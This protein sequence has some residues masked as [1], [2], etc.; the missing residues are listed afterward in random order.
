MMSGPHPNAETRC[1]HCGLGI[2]NGRQRYCCI[3]CHLAHHLLRSEAESDGPSDRLLARLVISAF[4]AMGVMVFSLSLYGL[5]GS[6]T[7]DSARALQGLARLGALA[8][9]VPIFFLLGVP[10]LEAVVSMRRWLSS[11]ALVALGILSAW[12]LS[13]FNTFA[14]RGAVYFDT[15]TMVLVLFTLGRWLDARARE[16]ASNRLARLAEEQ[17]RPAT[18]VEAGTRG[19]ES[20]VPVGSLAVGDVVRVRPGETVPVDG[21][22]VWGRTFLETA[23]LTGESAPRSAAPGDRVWAGTRAVDGS[24]QVRAMAVEGHCV[25]D[26]IDRALAEAGTRRA[27][28]VRSADGVAAAFLPLVGIVALG[29]ALWHGL[30]SGAE[31]ALL[32][33]LSVLLIACP[34]ALGLATPLAFWVALGAAWREG[35]LV[36]GGDVLERLAR[37]RTVFFDKTGTLTS[38]E[39]A[40]E[41]IDC[42]AQATESEVLRMAAAVESASEHPIG[43]ALTRAW[44]RSDESALPAVEDFRALPGVGVEGVVEGHRVSLR[45]AATEELSALT[46]I[47]LELDGERLARMYLS[48]TLRAEAAPAVAELRAR[49]LELAALTGDG[50][51]PAAFLR[52]ELGLEVAGELLPHDKVERVRRERHMGSVFVGDGLNDAPVLA[53][54]DVGISMRSASATSLDSASVNLLTDDLRGVPR[55]IRLA[56]A[57]VR[58][59]RIN[60]VWAF[61]YNAVGIA[62]AAM[63][64]LTPVFAAT[65]MVLSSLMVVFHSFRLR[66]VL[67]DQRGGMQI[68]SR[69][70]ANSVDER[71]L[72][73]AH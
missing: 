40:L 44:R 52:Q 6:V 61:G 50:E 67:S 20:E 32:H 16:T 47:D 31:A 48:D 30:E 27:R 51:G 54:A 71:A 3:G 19:E 14:E 10:L 5:E 26:Q 21:E 38:G 45:R 58:T 64:R 49:G 41:R 13:A 73:G 55:A 60:L 4:L 62:L 66:N 63:G 72:Q 37:T 65:A 53:A 56:R 57:A 70:S 25:R 22:V 24:I 17:V 12:S 7:D 11:E 2:R 1:E 29:T 28:L 34:C 46:A 23:A 33:S 69:A 43:R 18:R 59:A 15:A 42:A 68:D 35:I 36:R 39:L 9:S 8:L